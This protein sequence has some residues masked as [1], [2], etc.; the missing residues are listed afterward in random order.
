[1]VYL[2]NHTRKQE[3]YIP[4]DGVSED[5][6]NLRYATEG[7]VDDAISNEAE[8]IDK[9]YAK[10]TDIPSLDGY[11]T[12]EWVNDQGFLK[13]KDIEGKADKTYVDT[14]V[15][16]VED[17]IPSVEGL[18]SEQYVNN[19]IKSE[20][21]RTESTYA[22][23]TDVT[24]KADKTYVDSEIKRV[25]NKIPSTKGLA[26][27]TYVTNAVAAEKNRAESAYMK[28]GDVPTDVYTK[29][30][31]DAKIG[32][33]IDAQK[34]KTING[35]SIKGTGDIKIQ[36]GGVDEEKVQE[37][38]D[39]QNFK[40]INGETIKGEGDI[41][42]AADVPVATK[43]TLGIVKGGNYI[44]PDANGALQAAVDTYGVDGL[45]DLYSQKLDGSFYSSGYYRIDL[46][47]LD[48]T[49]TTYVKGVELF[50]KS[51]Q[52]II[53]GTTP[54]VIEN[55]HEQRNTYGTY[56][57][58]IGDINADK[59]QLGQILVCSFRSNRWYYYCFNTR[60][61]PEVGN[62]NVSMTQLSSNADRDTARAQ[63]LAS[64]NFKA[65]D[66]SVLDVDGDVSVVVSDATTPKAQ[67]SQKLP[68]S[69]VV[70][71]RFALLKKADTFKTINGE[72]ILGEGNIEI[73]GGGEN[74]YLVYLDDETK[75][76]DNIETYN[77]IKNHIA[78]SVFIYENG[79]LIPTV[80]MAQGDEENLSYLLE[81]TFVNFDGVDG[82][83]GELD[84]TQTQVAVVNLTSDGAATIVGQKTLYFDDLV[85]KDNLKTIN[86]QSIIGDGNIEIKGGGDYLPL[87]GG[88]LTGH[89]TLGG[90]GETAFKKVES[91]RSTNGQING[92]AFYVNSDGTA[93]FFHKSYPNATNDAILKFDSTSLK[94]AKSGARGT[95]ATEYHD[96]LLDNNVKTING[97]S[98]VGTGN[99]EIQGGGDSDKIIDGNNYIKADRTFR[100]AGDPYAG[101]YKQFR[102]EAAGFTFTFN[103]STREWESDSPAISNMRRTASG[104]SMERD[105]SDAPLTAS[106]I[107]FNGIMVNLTA[108]TSA[109]KIEGASETGKLASEAYVNDMI[110]KINDILSTI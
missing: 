8:R 42:V 105:T 84:N 10:K 90:T 80:A 73:E 21:A 55:T 106:S 38:I 13:D 16:A 109:G 28:K 88:T 59:T 32:N 37:M 14:K 101:A 19:Q 76:A 110:G 50:D 23:K 36:G 100:T 103:E 5:V 51:L 86:G 72:S 74:A 96:V 22:K 95:T 26:S 54:K 43:T 87:T 52:P 44:Y 4:M 107:T 61:T 58:Y 79:N 62:P 65:V 2:D 9:T 89:L 53:L 98:I 66:F 31:T 69:V 108:V 93:C 92:A 64:A 83:T 33:A 45:G 99:I 77:A 29:T 12:E 81:A 40:T 35:Q 30:Q 18:A 46:P 41:K 27:E 78:E 75:I 56:Y 67:F 94:F 57:K 24:P 47:D 48:E 20:T 91:I 68:S 3:L 97:Q 85:T 71:Y 104:W 1:M 25:E 49:N 6:R 70:A 60:Y 11:A 17:K 63:A 34:F 82:D 15:K 102:F 7:Y 39:A